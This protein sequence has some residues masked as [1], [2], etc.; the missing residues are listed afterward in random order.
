MLQQ[1]VTELLKYIVIVFYIFTSMFKHCRVR[2]IL[3]INCSWIY[4]GYFVL[5]AHGKIIILLLLRLMSVD[6]IKHIV[7]IQ[8]NRYT[9]QMR[10][11]VWDLTQGNLF[12]SFHIVSHSLAFRSNSCLPWNNCAMLLCLLLARCKITLGDSRNTQWNSTR[13]HY[14]YKYP[15]VRRIWN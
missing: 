2:A 1:F 4:S 5:I 3:G 9:L 11:F 12:S 8:H 6:V 10:S 15:T 13:Y 14:F 7:F